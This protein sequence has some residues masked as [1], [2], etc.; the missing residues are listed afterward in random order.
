MMDKPTPEEFLDGDKTIDRRPRVELPDFDGELL[1]VMR[2]LDEQL[3]TSESEPPMRSPKGWPVEVRVSEPA[4][5]HELTAA[6][7]NDDEG[8]TTACARP[9]YTR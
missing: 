9:G 2:L 6:G 7:G 1:P 8:E 4:G 3:L 5:M